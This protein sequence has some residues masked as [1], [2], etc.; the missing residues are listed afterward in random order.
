MLVARTRFSILG[1]VPY[2]HKVYEH[3]IVRDIEILPNNRR[4]IRPNP[5]TSEVFRRCSVRDVGE[6]D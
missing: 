4:I 5:A 6:D 2:H 1:T 3:I